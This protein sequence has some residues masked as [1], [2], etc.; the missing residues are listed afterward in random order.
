MT[1]QDSADVRIA[2]PGRPEYIS[3][4]RLGMAGLAHRLGLDTDEAEDLKLAVSEACSRV[5]QSPGSGQ[6]VVHCQHFPDRLAISVHWSAPG[7]GR[8]SAD[9]PSELGTFL[10][11]ALVDEVIPLDEGGGLRLVKRL[12]A[13]RDEAGAF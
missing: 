11:K 9:G 2:V 7:C 5:L 10:I 12:G 4:V 13:A 1:S 8:G 6:L 3:V